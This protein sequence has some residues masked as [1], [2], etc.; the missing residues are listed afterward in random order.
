VATLLLIATVIIVAVLLAEVGRLSALPLVEA[1]GG[2]DIGRAN[3]I[4]HLYLQAV[5][6]VLI[7]LPGALV[8]GWLA[9]RPY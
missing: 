4:T 3:T 9:R 6:V 8:A 5:L 7:G 1:A 2:Y